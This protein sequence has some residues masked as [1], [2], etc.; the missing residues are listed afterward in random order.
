MAGIAAV[1]LT[2]FST[3][4]NAVDSVELVSFSTNGRSIS[5]ELR[6]SACFSSLSVVPADP[7]AATW[8]LTPAVGS[9][10]SPCTVNGTLPLA[11]ALAP[12]VTQVTWIDGRILWSGKAVSGYTGASGSEEFP[13]STASGE[14]IANVAP[15]R[16]KLNCPDGFRHPACS[17]QSDLA[18]I[19]LA[20]DGKTDVVYLGRKELRRYTTLGATRTSLLVTFDDYIS[21]T[22]RGD[23]YSL[24]SK[25]SGV[26]EVSLS[27]WKKLSSV[28][29]K[30]RRATR[31]GNDLIGLEPVEGCGSKVIRQNLITGKTSTLL[32]ASSFGASKICSLIAN[33]NTA[34]VAAT[35][36]RWTKIINVNLSTSKASVVVKIN[37][38]FYPEVALTSNKLFGW[39]QFT[40]SEFRV[41]VFDLASKKLISYP[42][43]D[44]ILLDSFAFAN[45][46]TVLTR[47]NTGR[48]GPQSA[49]SVA[50]VGVDGSIG[51][52]Q[53]VSTTDYLQIL[54][55]TSLPVDWRLTAERPPQYEL[56]K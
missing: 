4:A 19:Q 7:S 12:H 38:R 41:G 14:F 20:P 26:W 39:M 13:A 32:S 9:V 15:D 10:V 40:G 23:G 30:V 48:L 25:N 11:I 28:N 2:T 33:S 8:R 16:F 3:A 43:R 1:L 42:Y 24:N 45:E 46:S 52:S 56:Q 36:S 34:Y 35:S 47:G 17:F 22:K 55:I 51:F 37:G 44:G 27:G 18:I 54:N 5:L 49:D 53:P 50:Q 21:A 6:P 29:P 31:V